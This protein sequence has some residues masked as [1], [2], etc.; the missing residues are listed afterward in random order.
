M[1][2]ALL[3]R[4]EGRVNLLLLVEHADHL[5]VAV[6]VLLDLDALLQLHQHTE[7][8]IHVR[9][10]AVLLGAQ[11]LADGAQHLQP[12]KHEQYLQTV[13]LELVGRRDELAHVEHPGD[14]EAEH[15][16]LVLVDRDHLLVRRIAVVARPALV[17]EVAEAACA[18]LAQHEDD[19][20]LGVPAD[21][22]V[23]RHGGRRDCLLPQ[24]LRASMRRATPD[25]LQPRRHELVQDRQLE[26]LADVA[27]SMANAQQDT[28]ARHLDSEPAACR[29]IYGG[30]VARNT[31]NIVRG[32]VALA[33]SH[34]RDECRQLNVVH[35]L[36]DSYEF[37][38]PLVELKGLRTVS[39]HDVDGLSQPCCAVKRDGGLLTIK[40][41]KITNCG[42]RNLSDRETWAERLFIPLPLCHFWMFCLGFKIQGLF[43]NTRFLNTVQNPKIILE[44]YA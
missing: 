27:E 43:W 29:P 33:D 18:R 36:L 24:H 5:A 22:A 37:E 25:E 35:V 13:T 14:L 40:T 41:K 42:M 8:R 11:A 15:C 9:Q 2:E 38:E 31:D 30:T 12:V 3:A 6:E 44:K 34:I 28:C 26:M 7:H 19:L 16:A 10:Q 1:E 39:G 17:Q 23:P 32:D 21:L 20:G 4:V